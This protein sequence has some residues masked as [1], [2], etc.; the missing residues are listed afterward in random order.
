MY[1]AILEL[2]RAEVNRTH[3]AYTKSREE[4]WNVSS[5]IPSRVAHIDGK[6]Q[7][8]SAAHL[9]VLAMIAY[10]TALRE[11]NEFILNGK[12]PDNLQSRL[13]SAPEKSFPPEEKKS[14]GA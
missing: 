5:E 11:F 10:T 6:R 12:V 13:E 3:D 8:R 4:H 14:L 7:I 1:D 9:H 2:L